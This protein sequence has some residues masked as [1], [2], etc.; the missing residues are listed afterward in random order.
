MKIFFDQINK[1]RS[2]CGIS[3]K[4]FAKLLDVSR[5]TLW[6]WEKGQLTPSENT[7]RKIA[8]VLN[9][10]TV[11]ISDISESVQTS[12]HNFS[13]VVDSWLGLTEINDNEHQKQVDIVLATIQ[14]LNSKLN[15]SVLIIKALLD[16]METMFYIKD[17]RLKYLTANTSFL[18]NVSCDFGNPVLGKDDYA[19][20]S[21]VEANNNSKEDRKVLQTGQSIL[22]NERHIPGCRKTKWGIVSKL[23][24][25]DSENKIVGVIGTFIDITERKKSEE[26]RELLQKSIEEMSLKLVIYDS[27][28]DEFVYINKP[29]EFFE[30]EMG[31]SRKEFLG[32]EREFF[33][34]RIVHPDD[35]HLHRSDKRESST[36]N[37]RYRIVKNDGEVRWLETFDSEITF[38]NCKGTL[39][40]SRDVT[41][42]V[43]A[44]QKLNLME[45]CLD[46]TGQII[47]IV[48]DTYKKFIYLSKKSFES[49]SGYH[50]SEIDNNK[51]NFNFS[52]LSS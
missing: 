27:E 29:I 37:F 46:S 28:K 36:R 30:N 20:F 39:G 8:K 3:V 11:D 12:P 26:M 14:N 21:D 31:Y 23:P 10:S 52:M 51:D 4:G 41:H 1:Y 35:K 38:N 34:N 43:N 18:E 17:S 44:E 48:N 24:V 33:I 19:F 16:S 40:I 49:I 22:R 42:L 47:S 45:Q 6:K 5:T 15:Q 13:G 2:E 7:I 32:K 9:V 25:F 50:A